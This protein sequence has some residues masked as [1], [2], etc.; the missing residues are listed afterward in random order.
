M[1]S[2]VEAVLQEYEDRAAAEALTIE[3]LH[4]TGGMLERRD[5]F[6]LSVGRSSAMLL[7]I[8]ARDSGARRI[9]E[10]GTSYGYS[11][12]WFADAA[13]A[14]GG[15]VITLELQAA[16]LAYARERVERAGLS[17][18]VEFHV[19]DAR[20]TLP[21]LDGPFDLVLI[22][23][24]KDLYVACFDLIYPKLADGA[25]V[26]ADNMITPASSQPEANRYR[27]HIRLQRGIET[28]LLPVGSGLEISTKSQTPNP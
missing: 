2:A 7:H 23:L 16:K 12:I 19:G 1:D 6:L 11:T 15:R 20:T 10:V 13:R 18:Y 9:L 25:I 21:A 14:T 5:E 17:P 8:L 26:V 27:H 22:D 24:W 3:K 28:V 4:D